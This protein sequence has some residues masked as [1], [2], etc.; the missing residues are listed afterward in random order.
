MISAEHVLVG[1]QGRRLL[2]APGGPLLP[3]LR[4]VPVAIGAGGA[5]A[6]FASEFRKFL[7]LHGQLPDRPRRLQPVNH[8]HLLLGGGA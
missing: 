8:A 5:E 6:E 7:H 2:V 3:S 1:R 4:L